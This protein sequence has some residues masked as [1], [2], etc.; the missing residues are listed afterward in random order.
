M[1]IARTYPAVLG[2]NAPAGN[3]GEL[4]TKGWEFNLNWSDKIGKLTY[5]IGGNLSTYDTNLKKIWRSNCDQLY[6]PWFK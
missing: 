6:K 3:N 5:H 1:L 2:A 4:E